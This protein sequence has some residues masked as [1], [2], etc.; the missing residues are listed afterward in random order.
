MSLGNHLGADQKIDISAAKAAKNSLEIPKVM[1]GIPVDSADAR[2]RESRF[3]LGFDFFRAFTDVVNVLAV[4]VGAAGGRRF[5]ES[6][7]MTQQLVNPLVKCHRH[8]AGGAH[9]GEATV[10]T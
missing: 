3:Q 7:V 10:A 4:T 1:H 6:A 2:V 8:T 9:K 5:C